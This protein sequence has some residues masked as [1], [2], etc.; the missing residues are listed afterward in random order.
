M[1]AMTFW[2]IALGKGEDD[3]AK[4]ECE[5]LAIGVDDQ[6]NMGWQSILVTDWRVS[7]G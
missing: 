3:L 5:E 1:R 4:G 7:V 2:I 6:R